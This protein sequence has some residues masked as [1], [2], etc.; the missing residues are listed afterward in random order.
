MRIGVIIMLVIS[1]INFILLLLNG[2]YAGGKIIVSGN[3]AI[4][5]QLVLIIFLAYIVFA[6]R[7]KDEN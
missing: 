7:V 4:L 1:T 3:N 5:F 6:K 2:S